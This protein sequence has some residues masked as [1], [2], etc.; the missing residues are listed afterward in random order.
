MAQL[1]FDAYSATVM[2][3]SSQF[4]HMSA[5]RA[6]HSG[7][8][9]DEPIRPHPHLLAFDIAFAAG[10]NGLDGCRILPMMEASEK[11]FRRPRFDNEDIKGL[12]TARNNSKR[13]LKPNFAPSTLSSPIVRATIS[14]YS[15]SHSLKGVLVFSS[16]SFRN[17]F[18]SVSNISL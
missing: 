10:S 14:S 5:L 17:Q 3:W 11:T 1:W 16:L 2:I 13:T 9:R 12:R 15:V 4:T 6:P 7:L 8:F 18:G